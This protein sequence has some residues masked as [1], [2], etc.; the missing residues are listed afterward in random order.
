MTCMDISHLSH[1]SRMSS[2]LFLQYLT[3]CSSVSPGPLKRGMPVVV[4]SS[5]P[6]PFE[7]VKPWSPRARREMLDTVLGVVRVG[8]SGGRDR[9]LAL[10]NIRSGP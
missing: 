8:A 9:V 2:W 5:H 1:S 10:G 4:L 6:H 7:E 3:H